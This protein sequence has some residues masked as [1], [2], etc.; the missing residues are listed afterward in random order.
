MG[1][2]AE[3]RASKAA[4]S[5]DVAHLAGVS[6]A[7]VSFVLNNAPQSIAPKTRE[8]VLRAARLLNYRP[9]LSAKA[10]VEGS[11]RVVLFDLSSSSWNG[12]AMHVLAEL[13]RVLAEHGLV[14]AVHLDA[15]VPQ[16]LLST[17]LRIRPRLVLPK[18]PLSPEERA[19]FDNAG[20]L[21]AEVS[22]TELTAVEDLAARIRLE[23]LRQRGHSR[24]AIAERE[25][26]GEM[27]VVEAR[28][29]AVVT[30]AA[31]LGLPEPRVAAF[32]DGP[33]AVSQ[34]RRMPDAGITAVCAFNDDTALAT[35]RAAA[36]AGLRC[37]ED[38]AVIGADDTFP[39]SVAFPPL[40][41]VKVD[42][43][44]L[45]KLFAPAVLATLGIEAE[46]LPD[47]NDVVTLVVREST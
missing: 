13:T 22:E 40:T 20:I 26:Q 35:I 28:R 42:F 29:R 17:A 32:H 19:E 37:P 31:E 44:R 10:L 36:D 7:T 24:I 27:S 38:L 41:T 15:P 47:V 5:A 14:T 18:R 2:S 4:T 1:E 11:S 16:S 12:Q 46:P 3:G 39:G 21:V 33:S 45:G 9:N 25:G 6:R 30:A 34:V 43:E 8:N 23:H